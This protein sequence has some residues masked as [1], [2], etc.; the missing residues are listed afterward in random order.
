MLKRLNSSSP[1]V[2][3][4]AG[5]VS[6]CLVAVLGVMLLIGWK[7]LAY[8]WP[9]PV[10]EFK[11][12]TPHGEDTVF[13]QIYGVEMVSRQQLEEAGVTLK[14]P[15]LDEYQRLLIKVAN[16]EREA[17]DF[18]SVLQQD[19]LSQTAPPHIAVIE[20]T[21]NGVFF[22]IPVG[23]IDG[24]KHVIDAPDHVFFE[25][26]IASADTRRK[27]IA[28]IE[29]REI[30]TVNYQLT[31][32]KNE[33]SA[34]IKKG[35][36]VP[37]K[38]EEGIATLQLRYQSLEDVLMQRRNELSLDR[39]VVKDR[40]GEPVTIALNDVLRL[41]YPNNMDWPEKLTHWAQQ[42]AHFVTEN[43]REA[44]SEGGVFPAIF[45]T[46]LMVLLMSVMV[47]PLGVLAAVY[48]H[49][50]AG[51]NTF[52]RI[53][54]IAVVNLAGVPSIVYG[55][56]GLGFFVYFVGGSIDS[57]F[58]SDALPNPTFG[59]PGI[60]WSSL[61]L[62]ILT[63]PVVIV[64]TE[65]GLAR[66]PTS[67]RHGSMA[68]G[69]TQAE[70]LWR[71]VLPM[72]SPAIMTGLILAIARAAGE[73]APLMLVGVVK[74]APALPLD[75]NFPFLHLDR[76]FMHLGYH[77][78]DVGFQSPNIEAARPL[79]YATS[80]LLVTV[81]VSLNLA[82]ITIRNHLREKYRALEQEI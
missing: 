15:N 17:H 26:K 12:E 75:A 70:T 6:L 48:L 46:V 57:L 73:V 34:Y 4:T 78:Y 28:Q 65:E 61:T 9:A 24:G 29:Q 53:I 62:A 60:L 42:I 2:W 56:F 36:A 63:L 51:K 59:T 1:W 67:V 79:V 49:E 33:R 43:P 16:R 44:N 72:A 64:S 11:I 31:A 20:R 41:W 3:V 45:G 50:Y 35:Q 22:G 8:F 32:L 23:Y 71:I 27:A 5:M 69:A 30:K 66:I 37:A 47:T 54:R 14:A 40:H 74:V 7:G 13:G 21:E 81:I 18:I 39:L 82:A 80:L 77:V 55:V 38:V 52:T 19:I 76:K 58:Y 25:Q 10:Y 68:L